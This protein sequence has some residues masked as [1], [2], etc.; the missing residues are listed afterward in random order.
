[1]LIDTHTHLN[2]PDLFA[3]SEELV[4]RARAAGV[5]ALIVPGFDRESSL[6]ALELS[7]RFPDVYAAVGYHP[8]AAAEFDEAAALLLRDWLARPRVVALGEIGLDYHYDTPDR[9]VQARAFRAQL[10]L[11]RE[12][13]RPIIIHDREAHDDVLRMLRDVGVGPRAG[14]MHCYSGSAEMLPDFLSL[15]MYI[16]LDGPVTYKNAKKA[17]EVARRVPSDRL[18]VETDAPWLTPEPHRGTRNEPAFVV[19]VAQRIAEIREVAMEQVGEWTSTN[20]RQL[21]GL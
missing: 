5:V 1:M 18:L 16:G 8:H 15:G 20:A 19:H 12:F 3:I 14:V 9:A 10:E 7:E 13:E 4:L 17:I 21:F 6:R 11:A 2:A